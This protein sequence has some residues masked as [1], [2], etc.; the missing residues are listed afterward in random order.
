M[1]TAELD[2]RKTEKKDAAEGK[3]PAEIQSDYRV[4]FTEEAYDKMKAHAAT[5]N[6][7]E[8][9]GVL[10]GEVKRDSN[11]PFLSICATIEG[12]HSNNYGAQV[13][14]THQTWDHINAQM[15]KEFAKKRIVGWYHTHPG[16]GVFLS[17]MDMFIQEN[18]FNMPFH[19]AVVIETKKHE[20]GCFAWVDG[21]AHPLRRYY[22]GNRE[23]KLTPGDAEEFTLASMKAPAGGGSTA[24]AVAP[25]PEAE[26]RWATSFFMVTFMI[27]A[28]LGGMMFGRMSP[29]G[30]R[31]A[32]YASL[33]TELFDTLQYAGMTG[34]ASKD[35]GELKEKLADAGK[36]LADKDAAGAE[37]ALKDA[38]IR[39]EN[40]V[41]IYDK[42]R[43][44]ARNE[45]GKLLN[46]KESMTTRVDRTA[47]QQDQLGFLVADLYCLRVQDSLMKD[48]KPRKLE[49]LSEAEGQMLK[50]NVTLAVRTTPAAKETLERKFPG[51]MD[52]CF[53]APKTEGEKS[54]AE[55][56]G[57]GAK[58]E[59]KS[60]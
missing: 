59:K 51:L 42:R 4:F 31:E 34:L 28:F 46:A 44:E 57:E 3:F 11:G 36:K 22:V 60:D 15:D 23:V 54:A 58:A 27:I 5:T 2:Y 35:F 12:K 48:G 37:A 1:P 14:F 26:P 18:Y 13:T 32:M 38:N 8:I 20:E 17:K 56:S 43:S 45:L 39:I 16:F 33:E 29:G 7:V 19:V 25:P 21:N 9:C 40:L 30:D 52:Y 24:A 50:Q 41:K 53:G 6:E 47:L 10:V 49:D 55:K